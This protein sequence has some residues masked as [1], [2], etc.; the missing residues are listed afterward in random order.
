VIEAADG[1]EALLQAG[2]NPPELMIIDLHM[3]HGD[4]FEV[5]KEI[6]GIVGL[7][8]LPIIVL[9]SDSDDASQFQAM[10]LGA[11]DYLIKPIKPPLVLARINAVLRRS[12]WSEPA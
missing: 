4:G 1:R 6:R 10:E 8:H 12:G 2:Q 9:T 7:S 5:I 3:P 11:D